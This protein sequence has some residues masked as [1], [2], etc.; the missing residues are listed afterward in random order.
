[1]N[2][3]TANG[4][5]AGTGVSVRRT[6]APPREV[7]SATPAPDARR[8]RAR[9]A[10]HFSAWR[11]HRYVSLPALGFD[12]ADY[13]SVYLRRQADLLT[14]PLAAAGADSTFELRFCSVPDPAEPARGRIETMLLCRIDGAA[15]GDAR[16]RANAIGR[17][18]HASLP[19]IEFERVPSAGR[20]AVLAP[21][22]AESLIAIRRRCTLE[23]LTTSAEP[24]P[25]RHAGFLV[26]GAR[27]K[28]PEATAAAPAYPQ[29][30]HVFPWS[31][32]MDGHA[33]L[34]ELLLREPAPVQLS[35]RMR[36][37]VLEPAER[38]LLE[39]QI[40]TC[41]RYAQLPLGAAAERPDAGIEWLQPTLQHRARALQSLQTAT[42]FTLTSRAVLM[43]A[44]VAST[45][46]IAA[47]IVDVAAQLCAGGRI[48]DYVAAGQDWYLMG[49]HELIDL[50]GDAEE[51]R[52]FRRLELRLAPAPSVAATGRRAVG[53]YR[54]AHLFDPASAAVAFR[55]PAAPA[56]RLRGTEVRGW[57]APDPPADLP[58]E[59][60]LIGESVERSGSR[61]VRLDVRTL[62]QHT[63]VVGQTGSGKSTLLTR[64]ALDDIEAGRGVAFIDPHGDAVRDILG[65]IPE[66][67][68]GDVV[69]I[70]PTRRDRPVGINLLEWSD[71]SQRHFMVQ[72]VVALLLRGLRDEHGSAA[73]DWTGPIF[74]QYVRNLLLLV[75][76][77][78]ADPGTLLEF[79]MIFRE[80]DYWKRWLPLRTH[81]PMLDSWVEH[82]LKSTAFFRHS[83]DS[84]SMAAY[85]GSK[86]ER[87]LFDPNLK[88][89]FA[90]KH[91]TVDFRDVMNSG[92]ILLV[93]LA[94]GELS[95]DASRFLGTTLIALLQ[96]AAMQRSA[97]PAAERRP[98]RII[99]D[100]FHAVQTES[101]S[102]LLSGGRKYGV[103]LVLATQHVSQIRE[104][105]LIDAVLG[106]SS[107]I[108]SFRLGDRDA[109][110]IAP[111]FRPSIDR[112]DLV[113]LP[114]YHA[115]VATRF[116]GEP[117]PAFVV[118]TVPETRP[119]CARRAAAVMAASD[120]RHGRRID[121]VEWMILKSMLE[122]G[123]P[124]PAE[125]VAA[126]MD[127]THRFKRRPK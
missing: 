52:A 25:Q 43:T 71:E 107:T 103:S 12:P 50:S 58:A 73:R 40:A 88:A 113:R 19:E 101:F 48:A 17:M 79:A 72:E 8:I 53:A 82:S 49:G 67:R 99:A 10:P 122:P 32:V 116:C 5:P 15:S 83:G 117:A 51:L 44:H 125:M 59:G 112:A 102:S 18:L 75:S 14:G 31:G 29:I 77:N 60:V 98:F 41:E 89:M 86:F 91:S 30:L 33:T 115:A 94:G 123:A 66:H 63:F 95:Q 56:T 24:L 118:R 45:K 69:L 4:H 84:V 114:A 90:Q 6:A 22:R 42:L 105:E 3:F 23:S 27:Q 28:R 55:F 57:R 92:R 121:D 9:H 47:H 70:D 37:A 110:R 36:P 85:V 100:E 64:L 16:R 111:E 65:R 96:S 11:V 106:N 76:S 62:Q 97:L 78:P 109:E 20:Q 1:M 34:F 93:N 80:P 119:F 81:D 46:P 35:I 38:A 120:L 104:Q 7:G 21:F 127:H 39:A 13:A 74:D 124:E 126:L 54:L 61:P 2:E 26:N 87:Y 108:I 68:I